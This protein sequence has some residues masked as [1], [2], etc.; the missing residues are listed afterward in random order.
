MKRLFTAF[1]AG[2]LVMAA[3][4]AEAKGKKYGQKFDASKPI[5]VRM[6]VSEMSNKNEVENVV[7]EGTIS[8]VCQA[9]GCW[10]KLKNEVGEDLFVKFG[11]HSFLVPK[12][13]AGKKVVINGKAIRKTISVEERK[14]LAED[15]GK[16]AEEI[17]KITEPKEDLRIIATGL[18]VKS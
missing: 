1:I 15:A 14:H 12:D 2:L 5:S 17:E 11:E 3:I 8:H 13:F 6:L 16:S 4:T 10:I 9:A 7:V 18:V